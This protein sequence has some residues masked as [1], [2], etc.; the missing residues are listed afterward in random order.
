MHECLIALGAPPASAFKSGRSIMYIQGVFTGYAWV[1][2]L[3]VMAYF[4][5][6]GECASQKAV[7]VRSFLFHPPRS[8]DPTVVYAYKNA[9]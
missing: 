1:Y 6:V 8:N 7:K 5:V 3:E 4:V 9:M 2:W